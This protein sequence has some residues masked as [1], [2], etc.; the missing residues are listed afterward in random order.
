M[1]NSY[2]VHATYPTPNSPG[3]SATLRNELELITD[4]FDKLPALSGNSYKV[5][6]V[7]PGSTALTASAALQNISITASSLNNTSIGATS[8]ST[9]AFTTVAQAAAFLEI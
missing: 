4:G 1:S 2:Y 8:P 6:M 9:G 3:S 5:V 7:N